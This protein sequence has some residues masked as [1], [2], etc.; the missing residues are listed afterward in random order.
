MTTR[1]T[2]PQ[3]PPDRLDAPT[4]HSGRLS[5]RQRQGASCCWCSGTPNR[6]FPVRILRVADVRLY[7]CEHC[8]DMYGVAE[9]ER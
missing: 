7:A 6:R 3:P 9:A 1:S 8:A 2:T 5:D 4:L